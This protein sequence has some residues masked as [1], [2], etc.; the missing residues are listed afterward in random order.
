MEKYWENRGFPAKFQMECFSYFEV[1]HIKSYP[2]IFQSH[3]DNLYTLRQ[4]Y[5]L[6]PSLSTLT[7]LKLVKNKGWSCVNKNCSAYKDLLFNGGLKYH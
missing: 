5:D 3:W 1:R 6:R 4:I 7:T 2:R